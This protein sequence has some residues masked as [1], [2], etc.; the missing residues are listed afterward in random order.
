MVTPAAKRAVVEVL[1][2]EHGLSERRACRLV[3]LGRSS[4][5]Y[6]PA[7]DRDAGL[8]ER[9]RELVERWRRAGYRQ[10]CRLLRR[11]GWTVNHKRVYRLYRALKLQIRARRRRRLRRAPRA[12]LER[13]T[14]RNELWAMDF[15]HDRLADGRP[16]RSLT[17][18]D[19]FTREVPA[20]EVAPSLPGERVRRVLE[21]LAETEGLPERILVDN[22]PEFLSRAMQTWAEE[23]GVLLDF[24]EPGRPDQNA[25]VE[26][27]NGTF[28]E[29]CLNEHWFVGL[30]DAIEKIESWRQQYNTARPHSSLGGL[31][32]MEF[33][34]GLA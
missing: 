25:F 10:L 15:V 14:A 24:I 9:L 8:K 16:I 33:A 2:G 11:E 29:E 18:V 34:A 6:T 26:S 17:I 30:R 13:P 5:R 32:P 28:R 19:L 27:F 31:T 4:H 3:D 23:H 12:P 1:R 21:Q 7:P 22:G 20:I